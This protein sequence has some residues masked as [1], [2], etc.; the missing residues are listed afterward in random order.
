M[1]SYTKKNTFKTLTFFF[2]A[3]AVVTSGCK[4]SRSDMGKVL[5]QKTKNKVFKNVTPDGFAQVFEKVIDSEK[6]NYTYQPIIKA[7]Y[8]QNGYDPIFVMDH[9]FNG[10]DKAAV[11]YYQRAG[12]HGLNPD[13][14]KGQQ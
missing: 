2:I 4:K 12:D 6:N 1:I 9:I 8:E 5:Y 13:L 14:F 7:Y 11:E 10:D 3:I